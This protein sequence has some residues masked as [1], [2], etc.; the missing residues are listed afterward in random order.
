MPA[1][2]PPVLLPDLLAAAG[3]ILW[4]DARLIPHVG[5]SDGRSYRCNA[6]DPETQLPDPQWPTGVAGSELGAVAAFVHALHRRGHDA[7]D[8]RRADVVRTLATEF[9]AGV[10]FSPGELEDGDVL[11]AAGG[12]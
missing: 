7:E 10:T 6:V 3:A 11:D 9:P 1:A 8:A 4:R 12:A 5:T 2:S